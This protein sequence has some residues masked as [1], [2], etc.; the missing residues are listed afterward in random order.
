MRKM[1]IENAGIMS[2]ASS[3]CAARV[4]L[5]LWVNLDGWPLGCPSHFSVN[6]KLNKIV[7]Y[8]Q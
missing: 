2:S 3:C 4:R 7:K 6:K 1:E 8:A 5:Y